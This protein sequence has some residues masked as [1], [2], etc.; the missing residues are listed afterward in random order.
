MEVLLS[1]VAD[2]DAG[3]GV[4]GVVGALTAALCTLQRILAWL[5]GSNSLRLQAVLRNTVKGL[6]SDRCLD[7]RLL[8][9]QQSSTRSWLAG[10]LL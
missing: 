10:G 9:T 5:R 1:E 6:W 2:V 8:L 4:L 7:L 3:D